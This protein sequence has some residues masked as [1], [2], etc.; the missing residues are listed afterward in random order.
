MRCRVRSTEVPMFV[1]AEGM[2]D[3]LGVREGKMQN[4]ECKLQIANCRR[5]GFPRSAWEPALYDALRRTGRR[6]VS[7]TVRSHA[8]RGNEG[9][10]SMYTPRKEK[11]P[12]VASRGLACRRLDGP[13]QPAARPNSAACSQPFRCSRKPSSCRLRTGC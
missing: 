1:G 10:V 8:E 13:R 9:Y 3:Y 7:Q 5:S 11:S 2:G 6:R 12:R 4:E